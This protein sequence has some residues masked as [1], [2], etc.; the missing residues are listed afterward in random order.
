M[1]SIARCWYYIFMQ[2]ELIV[3]EYVRQDK[4]LKEE[5]LRF[6]WDWDFIPRS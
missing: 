2:D 3:E 1:D 6:I 5:Y 4:I